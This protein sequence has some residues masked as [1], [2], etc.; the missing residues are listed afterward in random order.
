MRSKAEIDNIIAKAKTESET[1]IQ[2]DWRPN[3]RTNEKSFLILLEGRT[4]KGISDFIFS[5]LDLLLELMRTN[6]SGKW[7]NFR[8]IKFSRGLESSGEMCASRS[9]FSK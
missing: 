1:P 8:F 7:W 5:N 2:H 9:Y 3:E 4:A 6:Q